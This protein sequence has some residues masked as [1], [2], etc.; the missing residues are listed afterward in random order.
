MRIA[1][2]Y[3]TLG[4][5]LFWAGCA[6]TPPRIPDEGDDADPQ[7]LLE[8]HVEAARDAQGLVAMGQASSISLPAAED[9]ALQRA[10]ADLAD[11]VNERVQ[12]LQDA[13]L[14]EANIE[15]PEPVESL[16]AAVDRY[17]RALIMG[18]T[19]PVLVKHE[20]D[21]GLSTAW[22]MVV[23][24]PGAIVQAF[25]IHKASDRQTYELVRASR[26]FRA[27]LAEAETFAAYRVSQD[28]AN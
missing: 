18:G 17:L 24:D 3:V 22:L 5:G 8:E 1:A 12:A 7:T 16:T 28:W 15:N 25:E 14:E 21:D 23:E 20:T 4:M 2:I 10:R 26:A 9:R 19:Q 27:L 13:F 6:T 11:T